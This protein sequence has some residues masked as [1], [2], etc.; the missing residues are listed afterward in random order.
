MCG[1]IQLP[2]TIRNAQTQVR[3]KKL[4]KHFYLH[5]FTAVANCYFF[6]SVMS[7]VLFVREHKTMMMMMMI[8]MMMPNH[9]P[10]H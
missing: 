6:L 4:L 3:F 2:I 1:F 9:T 8:M 7:A 10:F 5:N